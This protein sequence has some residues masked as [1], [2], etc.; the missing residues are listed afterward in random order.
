MNNIT[1]SA[2]D[3]KKNL[4]IVQTSSSFSRASCI[5]YFGHIVVAL[6]PVLHYN[7]LCA[8]SLNLKPTCSPKLVHPTGLTLVSPSNNDCCSCSS[9]RTTGSSFE[10]QCESERVDSIRSICS[11]LTRAKA[12]LLLDSR[13]RF[14]FL[15]SFSSLALFALS[16]ARYR[17]PFELSSR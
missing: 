9:S 14:F 7:G 11:D 8:G 5:M 2:V 3:W 17:M 16:F 4:I 6:L 15:L 1:S 12:S 10:Q 13:T